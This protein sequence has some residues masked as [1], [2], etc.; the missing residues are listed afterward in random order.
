VANTITLPFG[1]LSL[2]LAGL[3]MLL[4]IAGLQLISILAVVRVDPS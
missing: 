4:V 2:Y 3:L 1:G